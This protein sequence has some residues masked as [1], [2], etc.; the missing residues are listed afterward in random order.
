MGPYLREITGSAVEDG[1]EDGL[2]GGKFKWWGN[3]L[4]YEVVDYKGEDMKEVRIS[5]I[6][7]WLG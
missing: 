4:D 1:L 3:K 6:L 2:E 5:S 7:W